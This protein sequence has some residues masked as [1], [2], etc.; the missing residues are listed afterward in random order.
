M[1]S[2]TLLP[3]INKATAQ[4]VADILD[5]NIST[6]RKIQQRNSDELKQAGAVSIKGADLA[7]MISEGN[8]PVTITYKRGHQLVEWVTEDG[9]HHTTKLPHSEV[10]LFTPRA[11]ILIS[12]RLRNIDD[13]KKRKIRSLVTEF[14]I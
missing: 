6:I 8:T 9:E 11:I 1:T 4:Q 14:D 3:N 12:M 13:E 7:A 5:V 2:I 10:M